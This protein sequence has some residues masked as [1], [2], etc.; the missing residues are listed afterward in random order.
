M[1]WI[2][3]WD[4]VSLQNQYVKC[5]AY[6]SLTID[7]EVFEPIRWGSV[8]HIKIS[9]QSRWRHCHCL[10]D[11]K[12]CKMLSNGHDK[13]PSLLRLEMKAKLSEFLWSLQNMLRLAPWY[14]GQRRP[15]AGFAGF[16]SWPNC[17]SC[18]HGLRAFIICSTAGLVSQA[19]SDT[20]RGFDRRANYKW[21]YCIFM[22][23][24]TLTWH[25]VQLKSWNLSISRHESLYRKGSRCVTEGR[26]I[27]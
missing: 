17:H 4:L 8:R 27:W 3:M 13:V 10:F 11:I 20:T 15:Q 26:N 9:D 5:I 14:H 1:S 2:Y 25:D 12:W 19:I 24:I 7:L 21:D 16:D 6:V 23:L 18:L 22:T